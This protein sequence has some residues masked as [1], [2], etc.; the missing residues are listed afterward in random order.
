MSIIGLLKAH[1][2]AG[3]KKL[4]S[5]VDGKKVALVGN[6]KSL[7]G[8]NLGAEIDA[9]DVV[10]R[11][12]RGFVID[13]SQQ[14]SRTDIVGTARALS[15]EQL[16]QF[17]PMLVYW[18]F[19]RRWRI[20]SWN[21]ETWNKLEIVPIENWRASNRQTSRRPTSGFVMAYSLAHFSKPSLINLYGFDFY[22]SGNFYRGDKISRAHD[23]SN[24][25][26]VFLKMIDLMPHMNLA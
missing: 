9:H 2:H 19:W 16:N 25:R 20:P 22:S 3:T 10:I 12:N 15:L 5:L 26:E 13:A 24:E 7:F 21:N 8:R 18:L 23:H 11:L 1:S 4:T 17:N 6:A 14:G